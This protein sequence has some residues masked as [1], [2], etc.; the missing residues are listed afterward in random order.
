VIIPQISEETAETNVPFSTKFLLDEEEPLFDEDN[1]IILQVNFL[2]REK[3]EL[4]F[5]VTK[6]ENGIGKLN[7]DVIMDPGKAQYTSKHIHNY[8]FFRSN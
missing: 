1:V 2:M 6:N 8:Y 4:F 5:V 7:Q 3:T